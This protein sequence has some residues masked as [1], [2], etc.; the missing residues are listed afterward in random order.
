MPRPFSFVQTCSFV[1]LSLCSG[2]GLADLLATLPRV[3]TA[4]D[5]L[6]TL[7]D[8][9]GTLG[10]DELDVGGV[11]HV[12]VDLGIVRGNVVCRI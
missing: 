4:L 9:L 7:L 6:G 1:A 3:Q 10:E 11:G 12:G 8:D 5:G 2:D